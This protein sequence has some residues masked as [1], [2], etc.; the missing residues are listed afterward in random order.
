[1]NPVAVD[2]LRATSYATNLSCW[3]CR[4]TYPPERTRL[5]CDC[6]APLEQQYDIERMVA[7]GFGGARL[8]AEAPGIW[9]YGRL[10]PAKRPR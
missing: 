4:R 9:R 8:V 6:G 2:Q 1:M 10:L 7:D 3:S 5:L